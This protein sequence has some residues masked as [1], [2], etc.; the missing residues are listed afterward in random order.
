MEL[1]RI[2]NE[3]KKHNIKNKKSK[4]GLYIYSNYTTF[5]IDSKDLE[6]KRKDSQKNNDFILETVINLWLYH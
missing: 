5:F 1:E 3:L 6:L 2:K 4:Y